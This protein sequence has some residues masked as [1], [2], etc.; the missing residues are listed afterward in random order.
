MKKKRFFQTPLKRNAAEYLTESLMTYENSV[1]VLDLPFLVKEIPTE[2][3]RTS[4]LSIHSIEN[5]SPL[6]EEEQ[7]SAFPRPCLRKVHPMNSSA[8]NRSSIL[9]FDRKH[10]RAI[11]SEYYPCTAEPSLLQMKYF[12]GRPTLIDL[13][14][15]ETFEKSR[16]SPY[17]HV[18]TSPDSSYRKRIFNRLQ[19]FLRY[20]P[21]GL[22]H[23]RRNKKTTC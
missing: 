16:Q 3:H 8:L 22:I 10:Y 18:S 1:I 15:V 17:V 4:A 14:A 21:F 20:S 11:Q 2:Q 5:Q 19:N 6:P 12:D 9:R 23:P 7:S 13:N